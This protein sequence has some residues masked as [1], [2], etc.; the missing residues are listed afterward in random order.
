M[1]SEHFVFEG[2]TPSSGL[3]KASLTHPPL[4]WNC[5]DF[6]WTWFHF[7]LKYKQKPA[8]L[9]G[10]FHKDENKITNDQFRGRG[11]NTDYKFVPLKNQ[12]I[13][14]TILAQP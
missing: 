1:G 5:H 10:A 9:K 7:P 11:K 4:G 12:R 3:C 6:L 13:K 14:G 2:E 8:F